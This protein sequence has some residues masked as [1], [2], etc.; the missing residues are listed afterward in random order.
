MSEAPNETC[1][2]HTVHL[3]FRVVPDGEALAKSK[4]ALLPALRE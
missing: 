3:F 4:R 1:P 2:R